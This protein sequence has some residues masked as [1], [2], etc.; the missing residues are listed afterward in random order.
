VLGIGHGPGTA[1]RTRSALGRGALVGEDETAGRTV[2]VVDGEGEAEDG[3][4]P[5]DGDGNEEGNE[6]DDVKGEEEEEDADADADAD[7]DGDEAVEM[8][9]A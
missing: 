6:Q 9:D 8:Q 1:R 4:G 2:D 7:A 3:H 5:D